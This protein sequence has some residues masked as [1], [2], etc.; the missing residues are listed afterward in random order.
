[1]ANFSNSNFLWHFTFLDN[2]IIWG[3]FFWEDYMFFLF[4]Q[5]NI[6][7]FENQDLTQFMDFVKR[8]NKLFSRKIVLK[9]SAKK[10]NI[11]KEQLSGIWME[12]TK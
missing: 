12:N 9:N 11:I 7:F 10:E 1:M 8:K 2:S 3:G 4:H 6:N 5:I